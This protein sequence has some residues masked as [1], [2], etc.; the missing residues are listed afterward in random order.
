MRP[1]VRGTHR[2]PGRPRNGRLSLHRK[3]ASFAERKGTLGRL[4]DFWFLALD[5][6]LKPFMLVSPHTTRSFWQDRRVFVTGCTGLVGSATVRQLVERGAH[7]IGLMRDQVARCELVAS[8]LD[9]RIDLVRGSVEDGELLE[10]ILAEYEVETV[11]HLA[12]QTIVG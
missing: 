2:G 12:A 9:R 11:I 10:R 1:G 7:V 4:D 6:G 3:N 8:G 5:F